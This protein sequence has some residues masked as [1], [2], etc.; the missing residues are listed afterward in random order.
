MLYNKTSNI[1]CKKAAE[2]RSLACFQSDEKNREE[3]SFL[4]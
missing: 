4:S 1:S 2:V 3:V